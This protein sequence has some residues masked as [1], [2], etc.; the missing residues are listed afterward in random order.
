MYINL[1]VCGFC[2]S[3]SRIRFLEANYL[4]KVMYAYNIIKSVTKLDYISEDRVYEV[5]IINIL[6]AVLD[7]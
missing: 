7:S 5:I 3:V 4:L 2:V 1:I 6:F